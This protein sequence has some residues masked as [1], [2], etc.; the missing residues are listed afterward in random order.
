MDKSM[1]TLR[2]KKDFLK[3]WKSCIVIS[4]VALGIV[5]WV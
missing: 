5:T 3:K 2:R 1:E 4:T